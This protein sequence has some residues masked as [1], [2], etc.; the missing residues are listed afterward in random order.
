MV[1]WTCR[2]CCSFLRTLLEPVMWRLVARL[3]RNFVD[4]A[5]PNTCLVCDAPEAAAGA[6]RHGMCH[7]CF[8]AVTG[9]R[10]PACPWCSQTVGPHTDTTHGCTECRGV[11][12]GFESAVRLGPYEGKLRDAV[13]RTKV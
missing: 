7:P 2:R 8:T 13:L 3:A 4:L 5:Y 1:I 10:L 6:H 11:A 12:L 9:D